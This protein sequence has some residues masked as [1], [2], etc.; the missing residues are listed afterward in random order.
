[1]SRLWGFRRVSKSHQ[2]LEMDENGYTLASEDRIIGFSGEPE[3]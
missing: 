3:L 2:W 1:M